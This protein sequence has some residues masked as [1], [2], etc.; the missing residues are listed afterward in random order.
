MKV[1]AVNL[2][3]YNNIGPKQLSDK[4]SVRQNNEDVSRRVDDLSS[5]PY[6]Y[7]VT[8]TSFANSSKLRQL[9][10]YDLPCMYSGLIMI[11]PKVLS[12]LQKNGTFF[13]SAKDVLEFF[14]R[15]K[16]SFTGME[17]RLIELIRERAGI[18]PD[19]NIKELLEEIEP[20]YRR[21][22]RKT[23]APIFRE[24]S[25]AS[26]ELPYAYKS[27]FDIL[28]KETDNKLNE[29]PVIIP[30]SSYEFKYRL[31]KIQETI[32]NGATPKEL[33]VL[34]KMMKESKRLSNTTNEAT[35]DNQKKVIK[36]L[37]HILKKSVLKDNTELQNLIDLSKSR[38]MHEKI[39]VPFQRKIFMYDLAKI[40]EDLPDENLRNRLMS[41][42]EKLPTSSE[43]FSAYVIK[44]AAEPADKIG[45]RL[46]WPSLASVEHIHPK[47]E[48][49][50]D[51]LSNYGGART[52]INSQR[53]SIPLKDWIEFYPETRKNCQ[54]YMDKLIELYLKGIFNKFNIDPK[55]IY[56]FA[57]TIEKESG[58]TLKLSL[59]KLHEAEFPLRVRHEKTNH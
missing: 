27:K 11:D 21:D 13:R 40:L 1:P 52:V 8:F 25:L 32:S 59:K 18:H 4:S 15:Y 35:I 49:G 31:S 3:V 23:Q 33:R 57:N 55:Y 48:G 51:I 53:K 10:A 2:N 36:L 20:F 34:K 58:G 19:K 45:H 54:K 28:M 9:F 16:D 30:F 5:M 26:N 12:R 6:V 50:M 17:K 46:L 43:S 37:D 44:I 7:P 41:I 47:S 24:L 29:R 22:L 38:L 56:E 39:V 42:A 14:D